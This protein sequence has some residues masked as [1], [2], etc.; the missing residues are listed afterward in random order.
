MTT[1]ADT[2]SILT[3]A[4]AAAGLDPADAEPVRLAENA[5]W[6]LPNAVIVRIAREGQWASAVREVTV[7][8]WLADNHISAARPLS[9]V[10]QPVEASGRPVTFW[11]ELPAHTPGSVLDV[12][13]ILKQLHKLPA[14]TFPIGRLDPFVRVAQRIDAATTLPPGDRTWLYGRLADLELAWA[15]ISPGLPDCMVHG[16]AWVGNIVRTQTGAHLLDF[17]RCSVGPPEW[18]LVSTAVKL[19]STGAVTSEEYAHFCAE[20]GTD[21]TAW[22][23]YSTLAAIRE[24]RMTSYAAQHAA[25]HPEWRHQAQ[26]RV[27]CLRGRVGPRPW[28]WTG[29]M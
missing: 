6:R 15:D 5:I 24:L 25:A 8:R 29:I 2:V 18:D 1:V 11:E 3:Q 10:E 27:D 17:E 13:R 22:S 28:R 14:P 16:D 23:G 19:T 7:A 21:V 4:C 12:A 26:H 9:G 20:Y